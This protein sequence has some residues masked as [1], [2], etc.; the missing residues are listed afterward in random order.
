MPLC[1]PCCPCCP[2]CCCPCCCCLLLP[3]PALST[4]ARRREA[5]LCLE[6]AGLDDRRGHRS[7]HLHLGYRTAPAPRLHLRLHALE[8]L[9]LEL[10]RG[11][12]CL[13][14]LK[15]VALGE[16]LR[17]CSAR[18]GCLN[19]HVA[20]HERILIC[21]RQAKAGRQC[22]CH[23]RT[24]N[25]WRCY[26]LSMRWVRKVPPPPL[27]GSNHGSSGPCAAQVSDCRCHV[28]ASR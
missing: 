10:E 23:V 4:D 8:Q 9:G 27:A 13:L 2:C 14:A 18:L 20:R 6:I 26:S 1:C 25:G 17:L 22:S 28:F 21:R 3:E 16:A 19:R 24:T 12:V 11:L 5:D 15:Q 7:L